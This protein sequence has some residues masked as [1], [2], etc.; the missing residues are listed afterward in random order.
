[1]PG[2]HEWSTVICSA[3]LLA[4][5]EAKDCSAAPLPT[6]AR[7]SP[8][9][10]LP[11]PVGASAQQLGP[12]NIA[13]TMGLV[14]ELATVGTHGEPAF[15]L[16]HDVAPCGSEGRHGRQRGG[17]CSMKPSPNTSCRERMS[18]S[19]D[20]DQAGCTARPA[21][22]AST[23]A[24][25]SRTGA[26]AT[27]ARGEMANVPLPLSAR[28]RDELPTPVGLAGVVGGGG[29]GGAA[30]LRALGSAPPNA[31][32][33]I[34]TPCASARAVAAATGNVASTAACLAVVAAEHATAA[35]SR[36]ARAAAVAS[37]ASC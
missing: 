27:A 18:L 30:K 35:A 21:S 33:L 10:L 7:S 5:S 13:A 24:S 4:S 28:L 15:R 22:V 16:V 23:L 29:G 3:F 31:V 14:A 17:R 6:G 9:L 8:L 25:R 34:C 36:A 32:L 37:V 12:N 26:T 2:K 1:M 20:H 11:V 19:H